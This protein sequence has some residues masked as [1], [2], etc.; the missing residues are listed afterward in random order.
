MGGLG[1]MLK[2]GS[3]IHEDAFREA[4]LRYLTKDAAEKEDLRQLLWDFDHCN[5]PDVRMEI[6]RTLYEC[7]FPE[8]IG[9]IHCVYCT[10]KK[11]FKKAVNER[12]ILGH[13]DKENPGIWRPCFVVQRVNR[14]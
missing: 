9:G 7:L 4:F 13:R 8:A 3:S 12:G 2:T 10:L 11:R 6:F 5:G 14:R 1:E